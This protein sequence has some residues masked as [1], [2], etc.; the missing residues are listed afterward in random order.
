MD[1]L[2]H[3]REFKSNLNESGYEFSDE[4]LYGLISELKSRVE[5]LEQ[6]LE[7]DGK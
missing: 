5:Y 1:R 3:T 4:F 2:K 7:S 6:K